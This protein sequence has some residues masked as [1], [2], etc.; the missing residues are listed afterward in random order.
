MV[1]V[2]LAGGVLQRAISV[3]TMPLAASTAPWARYS[4]LPLVIFTTEIR[5]EESEV[6]K[7]IDTNVAAVKAANTAN[8]S[9]MPR[10]ELLAFRIRFISHPIPELDDLLGRVAMDRTRRVDIAHEQPHAHGI[11]GEHEA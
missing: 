11:H 1:T 4:A 9:A 5:F 8:K 10:R 2:P 7:S 3:R 6:D